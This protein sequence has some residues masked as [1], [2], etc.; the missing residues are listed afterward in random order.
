MLKSMYLIN[1]NNT[2]HYETENLLRVFFPD[3]KVVS[4]DEIPAFDDY[5]LAALSGSRV[6]VEIRLSGVISRAAEVYNTDD[7]ADGESEESFFERKTALLLFGLLSRST[8]YT[9]P[10]GILTGVRPAKLMG[11][12]M[13]TWGEE[14]ARDYFLRELLVSREKTDL[15]VSVAKAQLPITEKSAEKSFS[16]YVSVPFCPSRCSYCSFISHSNESAKKLI[17]AYTEKLCLELEKT[18]EIARELSL[19]LESVYIGGGTPTVLTAPQLQA[20][21][22]AVKAHFDLSHCA[23]YT[24]EAGRPDSIDESKLAVMKDCGCT[25]IS[26]NPQ[27]FNDSVLREIGRNHT[28]QMTLDA[29][30]LARSMG[31]DNIN[32]DLIAGLPT[33]TLESF[34]KTLER[35]IALSPENITVHTLALKRSATLVTE[36]KNTNSPELTR[37]MLALVQTRLPQENYLPYYMYRQSRSLGNLENV[38]WAKKG[39]EGLYNVYMMEECH[40]ILSVGG[41]AV[42]KLRAPHGSEIERVY[43]YKYPYEYINGFDE[44]LQRKKAVYEFYR[45]HLFGNQKG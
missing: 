3:I 6:E 41:G 8:G 36:K 15:A 9:P 31:F 12:L 28:G 32:M 38:G 37:N 35:A 27:T 42:T 7:K 17:P 5:C 26:I 19:E 4:V 25:R 16:L 14:K 30:A 18:G 29:M 43:N 44:I 45:K 40:T 21:T 1:K 13:K 22:D 23:E 10:W 2:F 34:G 11:N 33:D 39:F 24:I 20:V